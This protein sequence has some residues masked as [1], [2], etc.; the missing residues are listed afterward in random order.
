VD[1]IVKDKATAEALKPWYRQFCKRPCFHDEYLQTYNRPN[2]TLVDTHGKGVER[3]TEKGAVANG[4]EYELDCLI[5]ATGFEVGTSYTRRAGYD[6]IGRDGVTLS[7]KWRDGYRTLHGLTSAG[8]PNC[9]FLGFVQSAITVSVPQA[10]NEQARHIT[11]MVT[12]TK[13]RGHATLEPTAEGQEAFVQEVRD[14]ARLGLR[15]YQECT[16]GY[17][18]SE[19]AVGNRA[20][21]LTDMYGAGPIRFFQILEAWR[22]DGRMEGL[23][24]R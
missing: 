21:F 10:L 14:T 3:M 13:R 16:P 2:V 7:E 17:Y 11:Y 12:E 18:N 4:Q 1:S 22:K 6:I 23:A 20:G 15:F 5:F 9:F 19:G 24:L 8:F